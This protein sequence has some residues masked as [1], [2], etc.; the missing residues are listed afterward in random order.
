M[1]VLNILSSL[2]ATETKEL[3]NIISKHKRPGIRKLYA[4]LKKYRSGKKEP[5]KEV[6]FKST[7][8]KSYTKDQDYLLRNELRILS[9]VTK[10][11]IVQNG[12]D[13]AL[14]NNE[15]LRNYWYL[16]GLADRKL[17]DIFD[18]EYQKSYP[19]AQEE[20][21]LHICIE[22]A[23]SNIFRMKEQGWMRD[24]RITSQEVFDQLHLL[25][26]HLEDHAAVVLNYINYQE[27]LLIKKSRSLG[28]EQFAIN[29]NEHIRHD[30]IQIDSKTLDN[31]IAKLYYTFSI[32]YL[33]PSPQKRKELML[34]ALE[35]LEECKHI[36]SSGFNY[37]TLLATCYNLISLA[38]VEI[39]DIEGEAYYAG[40]CLEAVIASGNNTD[41]VLANYI[42]SLA[43]AQQWD[44]LKETINEHQDRLQDVHNIP[45][46]HSAIIEA[47]IFL[48]MLDEAMLELREFKTS[49][50]INYI[51][52]KVMLVIIY[53]KKDELPLALN[54]V[55]NLIK[56][57]NKN[58]EGDLAPLLIYISKA[59]KEWIK[60]H[61]AE[62][63]TDTSIKKSINYIEQISEEHLVYVTRSSMFAWLLKKVSS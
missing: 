39:N 3:D 36:P 38:S 25:K 48:D 41:M 21:Q 46:L 30:S 27:A 34:Q 10:D 37:F 47:Y 13:L 14:K 17:Y 44:K 23:R 19:K 43:N 8:G 62:P 35:Y 22:M 60:A 50:S 52:Y 20:Y 57:L 55:E 26:K 51:T 1:K 56:F 59:T 53:I 29:Q 49:E 4:V 54:E 15:H 32:T 28:S 24:K 61:L 9:E 18:Q 63:N 7:F 2:S 58:K 31:P 5:D 16:R 45:V 6:L 40:K 12:I 11:L 42:R 33:E